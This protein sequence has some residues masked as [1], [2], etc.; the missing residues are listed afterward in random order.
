MSAAKLKHKSLR[1]KFVRLLLTVSL[2]MSIATI[3]IVV[4]MSAQASRNHLAAVQ[5]HIQEGIISKGKVLTS[6]QA[7]ALRS[8]AL[9][10]AFLDMQ[11]FV[12]RTVGSDPDLVY[13][14]F[15]NPDGSA[16]A[17]SR[18]GQAVGTD[19]PV[20]AEAWRELGL[21]HQELV[22]RQQSV[23]RITRLRLD[24]LEV[25]APV[26]S[27]EGELLGTI[28]YG[29]STER[30]H[31]ALAQAKRESDARLWSSILLMVGLVAGVTAVGIVL[32]RAQAVHITEPVGALRGAAEALAGGD[33]SV[34]VSIRSGD[35]LA[36]LG[37]SFNRMVDELD[38]SYRELERMNRTLE[39]QVEARTAELGRKNRD[40]RL[41]LDNVDQ[42]LVNLSATG[43][44][45][46]ER[47]AIVTHWFGESKPE[48]PFC[49]YM[50][51]HSQAFA[52]AFRV[53]FCQVEEGLLPPVVALGQ[54]PSELRAGPRTFSLRYLPLYRD[55]QEYE[56]ESVLVVIDDVT[57]R[58]ARERVQAE[59]GELL[60]AFEKLISDR[61]GF[62][63]FLQ[64]GRERVSAI[65]HGRIDGSELKRSLHTLKGNA[66]VMGL[67]R[68]SGLCHDLETQL[69]EEAGMRAE[70]LTELSTRWTAIDHQISS[71]VG[72]SSDRV[73][74]VPEAEFSALVSRLA[75]SDR[76]AE[77]LNQLLAWQLEPATKPLAR[78]ADQAKALAQRLGKGELDVE[79][80]GGGVRLDMR[81]WGQFFSELVHVVRNA[82]DHGLE[83]KHE[84][85][86]L[87]KPLRG[88]LSLKAS[89]ERDQLTFEIADDGRGIDWQQ[90][91]ERA[92][93]R[94]L[95]HATPSELLDA[96]CADGIS[97]CASPS[98]IS[99]RGVGMAALRKHLDAGAGRLE[100][101]S[102]LGR[103]TTWTMRFRLPARRM[104]EA[105]S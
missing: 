78:L 19:Q 71:F 46:G 17:E 100:V 38:G 62:T 57:E 9:D 97:T 99:G 68:L 101:R 94:G 86:A 22:V 70:S 25:A 72:G 29:L 56:L 74:E 64:D 2:M 50:T 85:A 12:E 60:Q 47:S 84:R 33:R 66:A 42:G 105:A 15:V 28:R 30:M 88:K 81:R 34:R 7:L 21:S 45:V 53:G 83:P 31:R 55:S 18:R 1:G 51:P 61:S 44:I 87:G 41:V 96:L 8:M 48:Q 77:V 37:S 65:V 102:Q 24:L 13:G 23:K 40:M 54:L 35:E 89:L 79:V 6:Q 98:Q 59:Y 75:T 95:P 69:E 36:L 16:L 3:S 82:V 10:N 26:M 93:L 52:D 39:Q 5:A 20:D 104:L 11:R 92:K 103:G 27:E 49:Q 32:S 73:I 90:I 67:S 58:L 43:T 63:G 80:I 91:A 76:H 14:L 4:L